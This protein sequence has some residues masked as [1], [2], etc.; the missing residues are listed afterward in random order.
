MH[1]FA[2]V[3]VII[4]ID[5]RWSPISIFN[6]SPAMTDLWLQTALVV[7]LLRLFFWIRLVVDGFGAELCCAVHSF[8]R[9]RFE[10]HIFQHLFCASTGASLLPGSGA[11]L[12]KYLI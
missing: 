11:A 5:V 10:K 4:V 12:F 9:W 8:A 3:R 6:I 7:G 1:V 2:P